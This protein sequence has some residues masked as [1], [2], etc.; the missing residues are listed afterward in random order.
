MP[1]SVPEWT[2]KTPDTAIPPRVKKR[3]YDKHNGI[4][5]I[6]GLPI[7]IG[8]TFHADHVIA[9]IEGGENRE[10]NLKPAHGHCNLAKAAVETKRKAKVERIAQKHIGARK[11]KGELKSRG[12]EKHEKERAIDKTRLPELPRRNMFG[13]QS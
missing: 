10:S 3:I 7:K 1:R 12:F 8:E 2:G 6:C 13:A 9:L 4:C 5:H 11:P